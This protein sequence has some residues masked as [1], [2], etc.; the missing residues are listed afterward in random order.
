MKTEK[1][2]SMHEIIDE[3]VEFYSNNP[4]SVEGDQCLYHGPNGA[5]C[6]FARMVANP[7]RLIEGKNCLYL[8]EYLEGIVIKPEYSGY[9]RD[10]YRSI[11]RLHDY[12]D[13]WECDGGLSKEGK[14]EVYRLKHQYNEN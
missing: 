10:F 12:S 13:N 9:K 1:R 7:E 14:N 11:Q 2:K 8:M 6:A 5:M 3:T 4:R